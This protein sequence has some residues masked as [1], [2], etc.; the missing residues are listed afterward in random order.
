M[1]RN[2]LKDDEDNDEFGNN[3]QQNSSYFGYDSYKKVKT[4]PESHLENQWV[5]MELIT[6]DHHLQGNNKSDSQ[7]SKSSYLFRATDYYECVISYYMIEL[8]M[9]YSKI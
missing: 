3:D 1:I 7:V 9:F 5:K 6:R 8:I 2:Y 4:A